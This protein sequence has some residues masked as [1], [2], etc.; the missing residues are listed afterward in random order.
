MCSVK[1]GS[2]PFRHPSVKIGTEMT[3]LPLISVVWFNQTLAWFDGVLEHNTFLAI[4][5]C[6][7]A[8]LSSSPFQRNA[9]TSRLRLHSRLL[10]RA[11][12]NVFPLIRRAPDNV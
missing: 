6:P 8:L 4:S 5:A 3:D 7:G 10:R 2:I 11:P 12:D 1:I 9:T